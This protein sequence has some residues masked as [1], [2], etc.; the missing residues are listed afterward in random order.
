MPPGRA[1]G[2][3]PPSS[4][5]VMEEYSYTCTHPLSHT[6][7][8]TRSLC[9]LYFH[10]VPHTVNKFGNYCGDGN[11]VNKTTVVPQLSTNE[12]TPSNVYFNST[13]IPLRQDL[14]SDT[15]LFRLSDTQCWKHCVSLLRMLH[16][17]SISV[18]LHPVTFS[19]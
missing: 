10:I 14:P 5:A 3:S 12:S 11:F 15:S 2:H 4:T 17:P 8:V 6:G 7:P 9:L 13:V 18:L 16:V 1:A 19:Q